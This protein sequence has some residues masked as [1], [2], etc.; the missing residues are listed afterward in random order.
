MS[1]PELREI[2]LNLEV[3]VSEARLVNELLPGAILSIPP[4]MGGFFRVDI[5][6]VQVVFLIYPEGF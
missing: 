3:E 6:V 2:E 1:K 5:A 4:E